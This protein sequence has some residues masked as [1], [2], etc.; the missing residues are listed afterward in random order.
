VPPYHFSVTSGSLPPGLQLDATSGAI[1][2][3]PS[4]PGTFSFQIGVTDSSGLA[5][6][7]DFS[8]QIYGL[9]LALLPSPVPVAR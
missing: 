7:Q 4:I 1:S 6:S 2:G 8:V 9:N 5:G 3:T